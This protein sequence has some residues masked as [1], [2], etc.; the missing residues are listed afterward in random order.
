MP[1]VATA[2]APS[3]PTK[4]TSAT[5]NTDSISISRTIGNESRI[6]ARPIG[7]SV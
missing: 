6:T 2:S 1:T 3:R 7:A 4:N 5:A